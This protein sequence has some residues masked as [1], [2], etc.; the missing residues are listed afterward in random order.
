MPLPVDVD[1]A[2]DGADVD[3]AATS[4]WIFA[5]RAFVMKETKTFLLDG[6]QLMNQR[7]MTV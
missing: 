3:E 6:R 4:S 2:D 5:L 1:E 7:T